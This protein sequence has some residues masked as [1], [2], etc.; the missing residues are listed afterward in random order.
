MPYTFQNTTYDDIFSL[1]KDLYKSLEWA[2]EFHSKEFMAFVSS[3]DASKAKRIDKVT[4]L[5]VP[6][7]VM[8]FYVGCILNPFMPFSFHGHVFKDYQELGKKLLSFSPTPDPVLQ[9]LI[10]YE[11]VSQHMETTFYSDTHKEEY[12]TVKKIEKLGRED[13]TYAYFSLGYYLSKNTTIIYDHVLY[14]DLYNLTY[15]LVKKE[16]DLNALGSYLSFS[17]LLRAY[18]EYSK[19]GEKI[20]QYLHLCDKVDSSAKELEDFLNRR[21]A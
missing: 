11:L 4:M 6:D 3:Q 2:S 21:K 9:S 1:A 16:K 5:S 18:S 14:Q 13:I 15:F 20:K 10:R 17:P 8:I 19:E 7:D 12:E